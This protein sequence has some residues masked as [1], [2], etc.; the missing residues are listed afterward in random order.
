[1]KDIST[2]CESGMNFPYNPRNTFLIE[3]HIKDA[4]LQYVKAVEF[5]RPQNHRLILLVEAKTSAPN[6]ASAPP[7]N[8]STFI[9][10]IA[11]KAIDSFSILFSIITERRPA[12]RDTPLDPA[13]YLRAEYCLV[14]VIKDHESEYLAPVQEALREQLR[15]FSTAWSWGSRP[16][17]VLNE[18][19][20]LRYG[21]VRPLQTA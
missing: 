17:L 14:L 1:M 9:K 20:A 11:Q 19:L 21:L 16:V 6:P 12:P 15:H 10:D 13:K 4:G 18:V 7:E 2:L 3:K 8:F 5:I